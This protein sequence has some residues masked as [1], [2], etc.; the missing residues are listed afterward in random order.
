MCHRHIHIT[1]QSYSFH[2]ATIHIFV[3]PFV[4][5]SLVFALSPCDTTRLLAEHSFMIKQPIDRNWL[6][7]FL[8]LSNRSMV[9]TNIKSSM[10]H[11]ELNLGSARNAVKVRLKLLLPT[12][13]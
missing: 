4:F 9:R 6:Q 13:S 7:Q 5:L 11:F 10:C 12:Y 2:L 3:Q 1:D 8:R